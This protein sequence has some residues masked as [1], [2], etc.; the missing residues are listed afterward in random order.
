MRPKV[1]LKQRYLGK[2]PQMRNDKHQNGLEIGINQTSQL[3]YL[4]QPEL[5]GSPRKQQHMNH[6]IQNS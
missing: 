5:I 2:H 1:I 3:M 6:Q 4:V